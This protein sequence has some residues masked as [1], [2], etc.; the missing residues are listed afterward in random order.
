M[1]CMSLCLSSQAVLSLTP[2]WRPSC[3]AEMPFL[4]CESDGGQPV[5]AKL[6]VVD[7]FRKNVVEQWAGQNLEPGS[8][9]HTD[10]LGCFRGVE[11]AGCE[12]KPRVTGGGKAGCEISALGEHDP[13]QREA[14]PGRDLPSLRSAL[15]GAL[16]GGVPVPLQSPLRPGGHAPEAAAGGGGGAAAATAD[17]SLQRGLAGTGRPGRRGTRVACALVHRGGPVPAVRPP[18]KEPS[19]ERCHQPPQRLLPTVTSTA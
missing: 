8:V 5:R 7:G 18:R 15:R 16:P 10:G 14:L 1:A 13:G 11:A 17:P 19:R 3:R 4:V 9:V 2:S 6:S 12:H